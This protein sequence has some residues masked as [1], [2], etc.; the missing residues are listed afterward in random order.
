[1]LAIAEAATLACIAAPA[2]LASRAHGFL[3][4][5][6][7]GPYLAILKPHHLRRWML[8]HQALEGRH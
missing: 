2:H 7:R 4:V 5:D 3:R 8:L 1:M 6:A